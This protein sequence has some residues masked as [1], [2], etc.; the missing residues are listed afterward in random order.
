M[1]HAGLSLHSGT[2]HVLEDRSHV[3][4]GQFQLP[5]RLGHHSRWCSFVDTQSERPR[6]GAPEVLA[7]LS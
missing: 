7:K 1:G 6:L 4:G 2:F 3:A 5:H